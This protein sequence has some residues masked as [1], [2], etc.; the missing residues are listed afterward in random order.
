MSKATFKLSTR[1]NRSSFYTFLLYTDASTLG[2]TAILS[3]IFL[4]LRNV[5]NRI[6]HDLTVWNTKEN[7]KIQFRKVTYQVSTRQTAKEIMLKLVRES[8]QQE[9]QLLLVLGLTSFPQLVCIST[10][11]DPSFVLDEEILFFLCLISDI[12]CFKTSRSKR[13]LGKKQ[14]QRGLLTSK[15]PQI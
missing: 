6:A 10:F 1:W 7:I 4:T 2:N 8:I 14:N 12:L 11:C 5:T 13:V 15:Y 9:L 3:L